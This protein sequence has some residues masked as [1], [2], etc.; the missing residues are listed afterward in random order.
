MSV[1]SE[2]R[3]QRLAKPAPLDPKVELTNR[4]AYRICEAFYAGT[5]DCKNRGRGQVCGQSKLAAQHAF[6]EIVGE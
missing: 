2:R 4:V 1:W 3:K 5:C 6:A